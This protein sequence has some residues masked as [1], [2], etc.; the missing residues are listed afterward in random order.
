MRTGIANKAYRKLGAALLMAMVALPV[1]AL[2]PTASQAQGEKSGDAP[3]R[4]LIT[5]GELVKKVSNAAGF[6]EDP[7]VQLFEDVPP[8]SHHF[9]YVNRLANRG[10]IGGYA[11]GRADEPCVAPNNLPYFRPEVTALRGQATKVISNAAGFEDEVTGQTFAD[12]P[13]GSTFYVWTE[14]LAA[15]SIAQGFECGGPGETCI[16]PANLPYYRPYASLAKRDAFDM[17]RLAFG[18]EGVSAD[19]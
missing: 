15:R 7:G 8:S 4:A 6:H 18:G 3:D 10:F 17:I 2:G 11:C 19:N 14:R 13:P 12:V 16:A 9:R 1:V 5:R